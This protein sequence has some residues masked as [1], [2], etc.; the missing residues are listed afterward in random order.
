MTKP[1]AFIVEDDPH[2]SDI[3]SET[4]S[5]AGYEIELITDG[6]QA[7]NRLAQTKP[8]LVVLDL[9]LPHVMGNEVLVY[10]REQERL[11][12]TR[13][14]LATADAALAS[15]LQEQSDLVLLKPISVTQ[16][17]MLSLRLRPAL[18]ED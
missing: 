10:I 11:R 7:L 16:L 2:L 8:A 17:R 4:V 6:R 12:D 15:T 1:L 3:F 18:Q 5:S 14:I 13:I 9:H